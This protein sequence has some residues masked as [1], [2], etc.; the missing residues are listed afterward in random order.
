[1]PRMPK[2]EPFTL[3]FVWKPFSQ[4]HPLKMAVRRHIPARAAARYL[5][6]IW[7]LAAAAPRYDLR[8][9][10]GLRG[11]RQPYRQIR[12][13]LRIRGRS[14]LYQRCDKFLC[15]SAQSLDPQ[16]ARGQKVLH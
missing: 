9:L 4:F 1:M 7:A 5:A 10:Q 16:S 15:E 8:S 2:F 12:R 11:A 6:L 13:A 14:S 3:T